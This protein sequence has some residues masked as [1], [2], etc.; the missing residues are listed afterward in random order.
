MNLLSDQV[1]QK[2]IDV[3]TRELKRILD[4][5]ISGD[6]VEFGCYIGTTSVYLAKMLMPTTRELYV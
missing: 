5:D 3:I 4:K 6:V 1:D 2:E